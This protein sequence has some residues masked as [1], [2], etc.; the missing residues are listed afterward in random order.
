MTSDL[1]RHLG[2][3]SADLQDAYDAEWAYWSPEE[4]PRTILA[5]RLADAFTTAP[6]NP[7]LIRRVFETCETALADDHPDA[8]AIATGFLEALQ[9]ADGRGTFDFR[10]V[11][12]FLG[13]RSRGHCEAMDA[14]Y[15]ARTRGL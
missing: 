10:T 4:P 15:G 1:L 7:T 13:P 9:H 12:P 11:A 5:G 8:T 14:F 2:S 3:L 6:T